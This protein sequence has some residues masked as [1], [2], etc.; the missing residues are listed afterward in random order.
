MIEYGEIV[1]GVVQGT[2]EWL[3][4][5]Q[6]PT[7]RTVMVLFFMFLIACLFLSAIQHGRRY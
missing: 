5:I 2:N 7:I 3:I 1:E 6:E 4:A